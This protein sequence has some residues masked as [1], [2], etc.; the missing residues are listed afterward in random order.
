MYNGGMPGAKGLLVMEEG[1]RSECERGCAEPKDGGE[2]CQTG[3][4]ARFSS[5]RSF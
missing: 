3:A 4:D 2:H 1:D 5:K